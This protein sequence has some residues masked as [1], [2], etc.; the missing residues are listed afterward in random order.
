MLKHLRNVAQWVDATQHDGVNELAK[1]IDVSK[2]ACPEASGPAAP[3]IV[4]DSDSEVSNVD[5]PPKSFQ[6]PEPE[7]ISFDANGIADFDSIADMADLELKPRG[8]FAFNIY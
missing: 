3:E 2:A 5:P 7:E 6:P 1:I 8:D 4:G